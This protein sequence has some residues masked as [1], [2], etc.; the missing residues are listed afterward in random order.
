MNYDMHAH[1]NKVPFMHHCQRMQQC[2]FTLVVCVTITSYVCI[3]NNVAIYVTAHV[4][5]KHAGAG[6]RV[7]A[8]TPL[9][10]LM[11]MQLAITVY[12]I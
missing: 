6:G 10:C 12:S 8:I 2:G 3:V 1:A 7:V 5:V 9:N 11:C 4:A